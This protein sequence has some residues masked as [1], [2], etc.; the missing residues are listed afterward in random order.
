MSKNIWKTI[1]TSTPN[2]SGIKI[3]KLQEISEEERSECNFIID[4]GIKLVADQ[5][6]RKIAFHNIIKTNIGYSIYLRCTKHSHC[7]TTWSVKINLKNNEVNV[8]CNNLCVHLLSAEPS[9][10]LFF[11]IILKQII[12]FLYLKKNKEKKEI[13]F[14]AEKPLS[15]TIWRKLNNTKTKKL[16][17]LSKL[18]EV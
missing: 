4:Y 18:S 3:I 8:K 1:K 15:L 17:P 9:N 2:W 16:L 6:D 13:E 7:K 11:F 12:K 10:S 14:K 5:F